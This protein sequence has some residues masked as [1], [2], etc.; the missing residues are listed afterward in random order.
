MANGIVARDYGIEYQALVFWRYALELFN[1]Q[2]NIETVSYEYA[3]FKSFDDIVIAYKNGKVFRDT[4]INT[5]YIQ[6]KFHMKQENEITMDGLL[7]P[8]DINAKK[9][10]FLQNAVNAYKKDAKKYGESIFVLYST[11]TVRHEDILNELISNVDNTFDLEKLKDGKTENSQMGKLR[12]T[13]CG[14]LSIKENELFEVLGQICIRAGELNFN[15]LKTHLNK[16]FAVYGLKSW[17]E[18]RDTFPYC[19]LIRHASNRGVKSFDGEKLKYFC[20][21]EDLFAPQKSDT[22]VRV[23]SF[24]DSIKWLINQ[25]AEVCDL[26]DVVENRNLKP[27]ASWENVFERLKKF[28]N[29]KMNGKNVYEISLETSLPIAF[30]VGRLLNPKSAI[31][32]FPMQKTSE[33]LMKWEKSD[34][35]QQEYDKFKIVNE[36]LDEDRNDMA[37]SIGIT[38]DISEDVKEFIN[39]SLP[40]I[41]IYKSLVLENIGINAVKDGMHAWE[42][43]KQINDEIEKRKGALKNGTLHI[44]ISGPNSVMFY[45]GMQSLFYGK[46]QLYEYD[47]NRQYN[48]MYYPTISFQ[49]KSEV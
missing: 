34:T 42:L 26:T 49:Q 36:V 1:A 9:I 23:I 48:S 46:V 43:S 11:S 40:E 47:R 45:L 7:D 5:E 14:Q 41:G 35:I 20:K 16:R 2:S 38:H 24:S 39:Y 25:P 10:S 21:N 22:V 18:N 44:F 12:K 30:T 17:P 33:G 27:G 6:V 8:S 28:I 31:K 29:E 3:E 32:V 15:N 4:T 13:L 37:I 19:E